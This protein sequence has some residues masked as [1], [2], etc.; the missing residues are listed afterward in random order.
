MH[1]Y[2]TA[3]S[4]F[5]FTE[6]LCWSAVVIGVLVFLAGFA[7]GGRLGGSSFG[8]GAALGGLAAAVP[9]M[10]ITVFGLIGVVLTQIGRATVDTAEMTGKLLVN[11][12][13]ELRISKANLGNQPRSTNGSARGHIPQA[14][15]PAAFNPVRPPV[16]EE[17]QKP[18][19]PVQVHPGVLEYKGNHIRQTPTGI[20]YS[21]QKFRSIEEVYDILRIDRSHIP[22]DFRKPVSV[23]PPKPKTIDHLGRTITPTAAGFSLDG[24]EFKDLDSAK[25][26]ID[27]T[28]LRAER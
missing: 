7:A 8:G 19:I 4:V 21:D 3:R 15:K 25:A 13:E 28:T 14:V 26:F 2:R 17:E 23:E 24:K 6:F 27:S 16:P 12:N 1:E 11:S 18:S 9:G 5:G 20:H 22:E 10:I